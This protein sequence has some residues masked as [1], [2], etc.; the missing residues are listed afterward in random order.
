VCDR[1]KAAHIFY[2][3]LSE[4]HVKFHKKSGK[5]LA[6]IREIYTVKEKRKITIS[7]GHAVA[8]KSYTHTEV[9]GT[10]HSRTG[11]EGPEGE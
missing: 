4:P 3:N 8:A 9:D 6:H 10:V 1:K 5:I 7:N 2:V 11:R